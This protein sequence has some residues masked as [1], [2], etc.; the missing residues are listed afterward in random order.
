MRL[1]ASYRRGVRL[2][3]IGFEPNNRL[4][5]YVSRIRQLSL[6]YCPLEP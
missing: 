2:S 5:A 1:R 6:R 4:V 3:S